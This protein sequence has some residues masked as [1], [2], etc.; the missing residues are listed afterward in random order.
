VG[1]ATPTTVAT[2]IVLSQAK[3]LSPS[4]D[5][6]NP[7]NG[8]AP[9]APDALPA[10]FACLCRAFF[11]LLNSQLSERAPEAAGLESRL[12]SLNQLALCGHF[13]RDCKLFHR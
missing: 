7:R 9:A 6:G 13:N 2:T 4:R 10:R 12:K 1:S 3:S 11:V 8:C 5:V